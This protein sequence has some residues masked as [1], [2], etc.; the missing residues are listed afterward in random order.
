M[1][2][3]HFVQLFVIES[4]VVAYLVNDHFSNNSDNVSAAPGNAED[5]A[6]I[7]EDSLREW[8]RGEHAAPGE[9]N[10]H[11]EAQQIPRGFQPQRSEGFSVR[12]VFDQDFDVIHCLQEFFRYLLKRSCDCLAEKFRVQLLSM[13]QRIKPKHRQRRTTG[14][15]GSVPN[16]RRGLT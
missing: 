8:V 1:P 11:I 15:N 2:S 16:P 10:P 5:G 3:Y 7:Q 4:K 12:E 9:R 14:R 6:S 13:M